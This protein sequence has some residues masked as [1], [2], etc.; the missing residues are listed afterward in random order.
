MSEER[1]KGKRKLF[2]TKK[3]G[4]AG[5]ENAQPLQIA[6]NVEM[7]K[8]GGGGLLGKDKISSTVEKR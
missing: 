1:H 3:A 6:S 4:S 5:F 7:R 8:K 2:I